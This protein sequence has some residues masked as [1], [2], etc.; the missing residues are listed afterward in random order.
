M[1]ITDL[2]SD[3]SF[4]VHLPGREEG[5]DVVDASWQIEMKQSI[6]F[7]QEEFS[8]LSPLQVVAHV[9]WADQSV[10][11][12]IELETTLSVPCV[13]CLELTDI[14]LQTHFMYLYSLRDSVTSE[15]EQESDEH[16]VLVDALENK[17]N[18]TPQ[19]WESLILSLPTNPLCREDCKGLCPVCG[20]SLNDG[21][22]G[23]N[24]ETRDPRLADL[25][26]IKKEDLEA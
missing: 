26:K 15:R 25:L 1:A 11:V 9:S 18:I 17:L 5:P 24:R 2:P 12:Q 8:F 14:A 3:W 19:V 4:W 23:C 22:C 6:V 20:A 21:D 16:L 10:M 7:A 13:R